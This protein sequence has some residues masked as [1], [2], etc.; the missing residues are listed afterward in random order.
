MP[1][2]PFPC[3]LPFGEEAQYPKG[4]EPR[5]YRVYMSAAM[6]MSPTTPKGVNKL[7]RNR[8]SRIC[9]P[10]HKIATGY[11]TITTRVNANMKTS[12]ARNRDK[13]EEE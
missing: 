13:G 2:G 4:R 8:V 3:L 10:I 11:A 7:H 6:Y 9:N 12:Q 1:C 5:E